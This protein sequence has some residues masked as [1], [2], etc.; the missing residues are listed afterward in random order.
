MSVT[1]GYK[2][3]AFDPLDWVPV[4]DFVLWKFIYK[5]D[6]Q[7]PVGTS[8]CEMPQYFVRRWQLEFAVQLTG[9]PPEVIA[10]GL[11]R[12]A[13]VNPAEVLAAM[14]TARQ[15]GGLPGLGRFVGMAE[16]DPNMRAW[17]RHFE[18]TQEGREVFHG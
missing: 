9:F 5:V 6:V 3:Y 15:L 12:F 4:D 14:A 18:A 10:A 17:T 13:S 7:D 16:D 2:L 11:Q 8:A 1:E